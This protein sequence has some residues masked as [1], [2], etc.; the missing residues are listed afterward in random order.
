MG[1]MRR[2]PLLRAAAVSGGAYVMGKRKAAREEAE[3]Q[4]QQYAAP[5]AAPAPAPPQ[6][7]GGI[8]SGT[9]DRLKD[10]GQLQEQG[11][12]TDQEFDQQKARLLA[13]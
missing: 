3:A 7:A 10:L 2:R 1:L 11:V 5:A 6:A 13:H 9:I 12:L 4:P 8:D